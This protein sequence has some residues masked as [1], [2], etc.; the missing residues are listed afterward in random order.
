MLTLN[1]SLVG[2][3]LPAI[4]DI[5]KR[6]LLELYEMIASK[7][8]AKSKLSRPT[9]LVTNKNVIRLTKY[10]TVAEALEIAEKEPHTY[11][12]VVESNDVL[13]GEVSLDILI[14]EEDPS[15][16]VGELVYWPQVVV[17]YK[18]PIEYTLKL[19]I[20]KDSDHAIV[21]DEKTRVVGMT[22]RADI[23]RYLI[24]VVEEG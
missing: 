22:T 1:V 18:V 9:E 8:K 17:Y 16:K 2:G 23:L 3:Q 19:M 12:P 5:K 7:P 4:Q 20:A 24:K 21:I 11:Y 10:M 15:K 6:V 13:Y 14:A